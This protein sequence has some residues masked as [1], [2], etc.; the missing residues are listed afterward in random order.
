MPRDLRC[1]RNVRSRPRAHA[2]ELGSFYDLAA[3][4]WNHLPKMTEQMRKAGIARPYL[5]PSETGD[6]IAFLY[7]ATISNQAAD[8]KEGHQVFTQKHCINCHQ[9]GGVGGV[10]G[11]ILD[12]LAQYGSPIFLLPLCGIMGHRWRRPCALRV[13]ERPKFTQAEFQNLIAFIQ[14]ASPLS[15]KRAA[16]SSSRSSGPRPK[17]FQQ[18]GLY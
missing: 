1:W 3:A 18:K 11:P 6:L 8:P 2:R 17:T 14:S 9:V 5:S 4:M 7:T 12:S 15:G 13:S 16:L 10:I